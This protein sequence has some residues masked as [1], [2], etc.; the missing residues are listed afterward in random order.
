MQCHRHCTT[1]RIR[2][3][4]MKNNAIDQQLKAIETA[5]FIKIEMLKVVDQHIKAGKNAQIFKA[6]FMNKPNARIQLITSLGYDF[7]KALNID[8]ILTGSQLENRKAKLIRA[9]QK[10]YLY[11]LA[12]LFTSF[13]KE[14]TLKKLNNIKEYDSSNN[15]I[16][17]VIL[18]PELSAILFNK[19]MAF[20]DLM[21]ALPPFLN[22][23]FVE[24]LTNKAKLDK[25]GKNLPLNTTAPMVNVNDF[26][27]IFKFI[28]DD[29][30]AD[31]L[32][33]MQELIAEKLA[34][35][36]AKTEVENIAKAERK[37]EA[38]A[39]IKAEKA[40]KAR[41]AMIKKQHAKIK[42]LKFT[43]VTMPL[44]ALAA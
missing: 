34:I 2:K 27:H 26:N 31:T 23:N 21:L 5:D 1:E 36:E 32:A 35:F 24:S 28:K 17:K 18:K 14:P 43:P 41:L 33:T 11:A 7:D 10:D 8:G 44:L 15:G 39:K 9:I 6:Y 42:R 20:N 37:A 22:V 40:E 12:T 16:F 3:K 25:K 29:A 4:A 13:V 38:Q 19:E 30:D